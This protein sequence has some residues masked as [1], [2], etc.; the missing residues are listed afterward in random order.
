MWRTD[1]GASPLDLRSVVI[2]KIKLEINWKEFGYSLIADLMSIFLQC[3][4]CVCWISRAGNWYNG[5]SVYAMQGS[6]PAV[7][8]PRPSQIPGLGDQS[9]DDDTTNDMHRPAPK[10]SQVF[11]GLGDQNAGTDTDRPLVR[12]TDSAYVRLAKQGGQRNL[13]SAESDVP[14]DNSARYGAV[15]Q[16]QQRPD[17]FYDNCGYHNS[18]ASAV[19]EHMATPQRGAALQ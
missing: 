8:A 2:T 17:W 5:G 12:D 1:G 9:N 10:P 6:R 16:Q 18:N 14:Q 4:V 7:A 19:S 13:L 15:P 3:A 11:P